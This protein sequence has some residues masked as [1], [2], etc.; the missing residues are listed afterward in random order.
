MISIIICSRKADISQELKDNIAFTIGCDYELCVINNVQ[1]NYT[2]FSAYNEGVALAKGDVLCFMHEDILFHT[3]N[4]GKQVQKIFTDLT[5]GCVGII[6]S[7]FLPNKLSSWWQCHATKG[8]ILQGYTDDKG[9]YYYH[10]DGTSDTTGIDD[11]VVVD[12][13]WL[14]IPKEMFRSVRFDEQTY[15]AFH[16][17]DVDIC[18]QVLEQEKRVVVSHE[19][20]IEHKSLGNINMSYYDQLSLFYQKWQNMLPYS[21][22]KT[23]SQEVFLWISDILYGYQKVVMRNVVLETSKSYNLGKTIL[24]PLKW[25]KEKL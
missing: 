6:G 1:N 21:I 8:H 23:I 13:C 18:M 15:N 10:K 7:F 24:K 14:C 2:I 17:Y 19:I 9:K 11:V 16:C 4:W 5:I 12:G 22:D 3:N 25:L 20:D